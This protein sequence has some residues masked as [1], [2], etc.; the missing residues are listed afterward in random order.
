[1]ELIRPDFEC[2]FDMVDDFEKLAEFCDCIDNY[3]LVSRVV[4]DYK[5][6]PYMLVIMLS[7][8]LMRFDRHHNCTEMILEDMA[9]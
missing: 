1:M 3:I 8:V 7:K 5:K 4:M 6:D 2:H 9:R